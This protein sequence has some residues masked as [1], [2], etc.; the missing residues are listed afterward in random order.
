LILEIGLV[1]YRAID[2]IWL[3]MKNR[4]NQDAIAGLIVLVSSFTLVLYVE[5]RYPQIYG[6]DGLYY[7]L[8][9]RAIASTSWIEY[10]DPPLAR[11]ILRTS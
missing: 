10:P 11:R 6:I 5:T 9:M 4:L 2:D 1:V 3:G 7:L 8:Q